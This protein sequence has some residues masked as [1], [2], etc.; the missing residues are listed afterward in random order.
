MVFVRDHRL[1]IALANSRR[2]VTTMQKHGHPAELIVLPGSSL[3]DNQGI[4]CAAATVNHGDF[5]SQ[6]CDTWTH[7]APSLLRDGDMVPVCVQRSV[8]VVSIRP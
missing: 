7:A 8:T 2:S 4:S 6:S 5:S 3:G 1:F